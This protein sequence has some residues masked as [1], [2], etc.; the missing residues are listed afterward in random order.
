MESKVFNEDCMIGM[1][2]YPDKYFDLCL[3]DP[4]YGVN[5]KYNSYD[6]TLENW[7]ELMIKFI[8]EAIRVSKMVI[9][10]SCSINKMAWIYNNFPPDWLIC[11]YKGSPG[12]NSFV[13]FNDW[14]PLLVYGK[15]KGICIH[16]YVNIRNGEEMGSHNHPCPKPIKWFEYFYKKILNGKGNVLDCFMGSGTSAIAAHRQGLSYVGFELDKDYFDAA[17]KR[18]QNHIKQLNLFQP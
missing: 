18:Y 12:H 11:W 7:Q 4:P 2:R 10:P 9:M 15:T 3:T 14:E 13:G 6:D 5:L 8:P 17:E 1:S 16:D